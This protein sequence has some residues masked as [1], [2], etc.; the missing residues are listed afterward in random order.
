MPQLFDFSSSMSHIFGIRICGGN[1]ERLWH[2]TLVLPAWKI[3]RSIHRKIRSLQYRFQPRHQHHIVRTGLK[4]GPHSSEVLLLHAAFSILMKSVDNRYGS[5]DALRQHTE[6][7]H[8]AK[9]GYEPEGWL[10]QDQE[11]H[12]ELLALSSW[13]VE[14]RPDLLNEV[15]RLAKNSGKGIKFKNV[16]DKETGIKSFVIS[17]DSSRSD[18]GTLHRKK[19]KQLRDLD[20][21]MLRRLI[22]LR[23][24][25]D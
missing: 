14:T 21:E 6:E 3:G 11:Y 9:P 18:T 23:H 16:L 24:N 20:T 22:D 13:W 1:S 10:K 19:S 25:L 4:P 5:L 8:A 15:I 17:R 2:R 12:K 7:L